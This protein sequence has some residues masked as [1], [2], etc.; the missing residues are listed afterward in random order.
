MNMRAF[1]LALLAG[2]L[3]VAQEPPPKPTPAATAPL[4]FFSQRFKYHWDQL[5]P[6][7]AEVDGIRILSI[8]FNRRELKSGPF[9][10]AE[11]GTRARIEVANSSKRARAVGFA[12]AV[13]DGDDRLLGVAS[14]GTRLFSL[15]PNTTT[16]YDLNFDQVLERLP[17]GATFVL[18]VEMGE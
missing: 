8:F 7:K 1:P 14:G 3:L 6:M 16:S 11:F 18:S 12:V 13:F 2:G 17:H 4:S 15:K 10:G 5:I 9:K